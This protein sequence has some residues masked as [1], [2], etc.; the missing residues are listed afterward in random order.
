MLLICSLIHCGSLPR[1]ARELCRFME[2]SFPKF[3]TCHSCGAQRRVMRKEV[4]E[5][6]EGVA[7]IAWARCRKCH[8]TFVRFIGDKR[9]AGKLMERWLDVH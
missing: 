4:F 6:P 7:G 2:L 5:M 3:I 1:Y 8:H 9:P